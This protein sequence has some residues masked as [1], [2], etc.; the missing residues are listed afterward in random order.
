MISL[1]LNEID[2]HC[3]KFGK[4]PSKIVL[5]DDNYKKFIDEASQFLTKDNDI[6]DVNKVCGID[7]EKS[8]LFIPEYLFIL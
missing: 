5:S 8:S 1:V 4:D 3:L 6:K 2:K 7:I